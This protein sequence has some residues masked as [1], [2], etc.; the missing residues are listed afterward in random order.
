[1]TYEWVSCLWHVEEFLRLPLLEF[2]PWSLKDVWL[3]FR[4]YSEWTEITVGL[5]EII[6]GAQ[7]HL[8]TILI[9][10]LVI[11]TDRRN[12]EEAHYLVESIL[13]SCGKRL[14]PERDWEYVV[15]VT[16]INHLVEIFLSYQHSLFL[17]RL[18]S[19][20]KRIKVSI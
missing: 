17:L 16:T 2:P 8:I 19:T 20:K 12:H 4:C 1:M 14:K 5:E 10:T 3:P 7:K 18:H 11:Y 13:K 9:I 15:K 6:N